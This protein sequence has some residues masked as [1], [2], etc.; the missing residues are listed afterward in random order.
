MGCKQSCVTIKFKVSLKVIRESSGQRNE[1]FSYIMK[2]LFTIINFKEQEEVIFFE[3]RCILSLRAQLF[4]EETYL[5]LC[6]SYKEGVLSNLRELFCTIK[7]TVFKINKQ[8]YALIDTISYDFFKRQ[9]C[10][11]MTNQ[12]PD[13]T[14]TAFHRKVFSV[15]LKHIFKLH[16]VSK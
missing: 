3:K 11:Q 1:N 15:K 12:C 10:S 5:L 9:K 14:L 6:K 2:N 13:N 4:S 8:I 7:F 16:K